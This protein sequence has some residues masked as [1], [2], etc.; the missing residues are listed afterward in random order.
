MI[1]P[2]TAA[3][4]AAVVAG[5][6]VSVLGYMA[7]VRDAPRR[8][9]QLRAQLRMT[10]QLAEDI[11]QLLKTKPQLPVASLEQALTEFQAILDELEERTRAANTDGLKKYIWPFNE[12]DT[13]RYLSDIEHYKTAFISFFTLHNL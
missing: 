5:L 6:A 12:D 4:T 1:D 9:Q 8:A 2:Y 7:K 3:K 13:E 10:H 11:I